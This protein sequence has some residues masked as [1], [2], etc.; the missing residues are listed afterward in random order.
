MIAHKCGP[1]DHKIIGA[2]DGGGMETAMSE[3]PKR[4]IRIDYDS[5]VILTMAIASLIVLIVNGLMNGIPTALCFSVYRSSF[6][7]PLTYVRLFCH[8][9]GHADFSHF[10]G[11]VSLLLIVGPV[12]ERRYG[13]LD[14]LFAILFTA[15]VEGGIHCLVSPNT[16]LLGM[17]G[18][19]FMLIFLA[20]IKDIGDG[21]ISLT[22]ILVALIWFGEAIYTGIIV[23]DS[24][25]QLCHIVGG[26][27]GIL[28]GWY[29]GKH[30][31][32]RHH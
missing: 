28:S 6:S 25:S 10:F 29:F 16:A 9:L 27:C 8:V 21:K 17:S 23:Q 30:R 18:V 7:D 22:F 13:S 3:K 31:R 26:C 2:A 5:P 32:R 12:V 20:S 1:E 24:I 4:R 11:N 14:L 15:A 19:V